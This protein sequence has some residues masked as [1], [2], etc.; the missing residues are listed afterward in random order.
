ME[1]S[2]HT[3]HFLRKTLAFTGTVAHSSWA[4]PSACTA[5]SLRKMPAFTGLRATCNARF[6]NLS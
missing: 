5:S 2:E 1:A 3:P 4:R 6:R